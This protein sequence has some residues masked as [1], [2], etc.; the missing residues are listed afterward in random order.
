MVVERL[1]YFDKM[2]AIFLDETKF[3]KMNK[4]KD[5]TPAIEKATTK[6]LHHLKQ[7]SILTSNMLKDLRPT[8]TLIPR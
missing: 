3:R 8:G 6:L 2:K 1:V 7:N 5:N 4:E